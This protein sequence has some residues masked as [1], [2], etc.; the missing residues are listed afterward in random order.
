[1]KYSIIMPYYNREKQLETTLISFRAHYHM[2][3]DFE[4][5]IPLD[6]KHEGELNID[7]D[8]PIRLIKSEWDKN[9]SNPAPLFNE[10]ANAARGQYFVI[11]NPECFHATD[12]L[13]ELDNIFHADENS[14]VVCACKALKENGDFYL[15]YQNTKAH[16]RNLCYHFCSAISRFNYFRHGGFDED[17]A[18]G[19][20]Y[21]DDAFRDNLL[22]QKNVHFVVR[23]DM[24]VV[25]QWHSK[26]RPVDYRDRLCENKKIYERKY[27]R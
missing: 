14:Y 17:F 18:H 20:S 10:G 4:V 9:I 22:R 1:M 24:V 21:E 19:W 3:S 5:V 2:R 13:G 6:P 16:G 27:K 12:I 26:S 25:H 7:F 15:W 8:F 11:T 23:D